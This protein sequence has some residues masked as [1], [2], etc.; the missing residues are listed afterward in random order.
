M[1][2]LSELARKAASLVQ[3]TSCV[4]VLVLFMMRNGRLLLRGVRQGLDTWHQAHSALLLFIHQTG[5]D[6][7]RRSLPRAR[8]YSCPI[9]YHPNHHTA[10]ETSDPREYSS[11]LTGIWYYGYPMTILLSN[12]APHH[13]SLPRIQSYICRPH[14]GRWMITEFIRRDRKRWSKMRLF[15]TTQ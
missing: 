11:G 2:E 10:R 9:G 15:E 4:V 12:T 6:T 3:D 1:Q 5:K 7:C 14:N 13:I 8:D